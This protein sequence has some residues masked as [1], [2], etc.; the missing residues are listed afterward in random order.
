MMNKGTSIVGFLLCFLAGMALM[1]GIEHSRRGFEIAAE[2]QG[3]WSDRESPVPVDSQDPAW[4]SRAAPVTMVIFS[5]FECPFCSR[6]EATIDQLKTIYGKERLRIVWKN[7]PIA[8]HRHA[9]PAAEAAQGV[10][11]LAG[12]DAFWK[13]HDVAFKNQR[14]LGLESYVKWAKEAG[15]KD[16]SKFRQG[17][18]GHL[19]AAKVDR[20]SAE[21][22]KA[23]VNSTPAFLVNGFAFVGAQPIDK[24]KEVID[25]EL[26]KARGAL[27]RGTPADKIYVE[28]SKQNR[29]AAPPPPQPKAEAAPEEDKTVWKIA[30]GDA[31]LSG[32]DTALVTIVEFSDF[33]CPFSKRAQDTLQQIRDIYGDKVRFAW[34]HE[35]LSFHPRAIPA[36]ELSLFALKEKGS[37]GFWSMH[38]QLFALQP[39]LEDADLEE[40]ARRA[41]L[42]VGRAKR[43]IENRKSRDVIDADLDLAET[44]NATSTPHFFINGRRLVGAMPLE[45]FR[46]LIDEQLK[47]AEAVVA[48]GVSPSR[49]YDEIMKTAK[50]A[51][52]PERKTVAAPTSDN[53]Y[54]G[55]AHAKVVIQEFSDFQCP[56]CQHAEPVIKQIRAAYGDKVKIVW[57]HR[58]LSMHPDAPLASEATIEAF[59]QKGGDAFWKMHDLLFQNQATPDGLKREALEKYAEQLALDGPRFR[60]ALDNRAHKAVVDADS[61][62]ADD[63]GISATP[64]FVINGYYITGAQPFAKYKK[65]IDRA[66]AEAR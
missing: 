12:N 40:A 58:P 45:R 49:V 27:S 38:D 3:A 33:Q 59:K 31:P 47:V 56:F 32:P 62:V 19:W 39:K 22:Q 41:G 44:V 9:K 63:A 48:R 61:K 26:A 4:G 8:G 10:Y 20:D 34:K 53:P 60:A 14:E 6:V 15:V 55:G 11:A 7:N 36:A 24:F 29:A 46:A 52:A 30:L 37:K 57:R 43:A 25:A 2:T 51:P 50:D 42:D 18:D 64:A 35:P 1:Y 66:L 65:L 13:F 23:G 54:Q 21:G 17:L 28:M 5:D 16:E